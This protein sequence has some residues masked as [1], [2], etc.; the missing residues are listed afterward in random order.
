MDAPLR[1]EVDRGGDIYL[2]GQTEGNFAGT[3][4]GSLDSI[5]VKYDRDGFFLNAEQWGDGGSDTAYG[6]AFDFA[7]NA[8]IAGSTSKLQPNGAVRAHLYVRKYTATGN[9]LWEKFYFFPSP[10][11]FVIPTSGRGIV[12]HPWDN[13]LYVTGHS[14]ELN[15]N[16]AQKP[17]TVFL[18][19]LD[20]AGNEIW[21]REMQADPPEQGNKKNVSQAYDIAID[22]WANVYV[23]GSTN[24]FRKASS[25]GNGPSR[26]A[27]VIKYDQWGNEKWRKIFDSA[28]TDTVDIGYSVDIDPAGTIWMVGLTTGSM[29]GNP[30]NGPN[31]F[32]VTRI[33]PH[34]VPWTYF[35]EQYGSDGPDPAQGLEIDNN[36]VAYL[37]GTTGGDLDGE[38]HQGGQADGFVFRYDPLNNQGPNLIRNGNFDDE[39]DHWI[40]W[41]TLEGTDIFDASSGFAHAAITDGDWDVWDVGI[42]Q[43]QLN[44][45]NGKSYRVSFRAK[46]DVGRHIQVQVEETH[47]PWTNYSNYESFYLGTSWD[48]YSFEFAM[49]DTTDS[50]AQLEFD[51][52]YWDTGVSIDDVVLEEI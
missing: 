18:M 46:S 2:V 4:N 28:G 44:I 50:D 35:V 12:H 16:G 6:I 41:S 31:D 14:G 34:P 38:A 5:M 49:T 43:P 27:F 21:R 32:F 36:G 23:T 17:R 3:N 37:G 10:G 24:N 29:G 30:V 42:R 20:L 9:F 40:V 22:Q 51:L 45:E 25:G 26:D 47:A 15:P 48:D 33:N 8:Y 52:G 1:A 7:N 39:F 13:Y 11:G 19:K